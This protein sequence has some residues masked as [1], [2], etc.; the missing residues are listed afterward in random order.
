MVDKGEQVEAEEPEVQPLEET[1]EKPDQETATQSGVTQEQLNDLK[2]QLDRLERSNEGLRG[3]LKEK[4]R[5]LKS[6]QTT[7]DDDLGFYEKMIQGLKSKPE[8]TDSPDPAIT[9][10]EAELAS[11]KQRQEQQKLYQQM[12]AYA[13]DQRDKIEN[14]IREAGLDP[15]DERFEDAWE[16][17]DM[18]YNSDG[19]FERVAKRVN[20]IL[21]QVEPKE[22]EVDKSSDEKLKEKVRKEILMERGELEAETGQ[23]KGSAKSFADIEERFGKGEIDY[24]EY[25][26][27]RRKQ[28]IY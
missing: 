8:Y 25:A 18:T 14:K 2:G 5:L 17:F 4:D 9:V 1:L 10:L 19:K 11:R 7:P 26:E 23:P 16:W 3:S 12:D 13:T 20:R 28:G 6:R 27:A 15:S 22:K 21:K 24:A